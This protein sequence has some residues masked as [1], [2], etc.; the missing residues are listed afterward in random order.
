MCLVN[1]KTFKLCG[2]M[3]LTV[4]TAAF[5]I[6]EIIFGIA[7][8]AGNITMGWSGVIAIIFGIICVSVLFAPKNRG[9][10][11]A[12]VIFYWIEVAC[13]IIS[14]IWGVIV[15]A[16]FEKFYD[17]GDYSAYGGVE[18]ACTGVKTMLYIVLGI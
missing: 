7:L 17:C 12:I 3:D 18:D 8:C 14:I 10:R 15:I 13:F 6:L 4:A 5:G 11:T 2:C 16:M 9:I 1:K